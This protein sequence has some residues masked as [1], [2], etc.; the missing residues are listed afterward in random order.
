[1]QR[2]VLKIIVVILA[3]LHGVLAAQEKTLIWINVSENYGLE[4]ELEYV[5]FSVQLDAVL[6]E[7]DKISFF[8]Q[9]LNTAQT[10]DCQVSFI[11]S[12]SAHNKILARIIFPVSCRAYEKNEYLL[13]T[14][15]TEDIVYS[16]L[17]LRG[18]GTELIIENKYYRADLRKNDNVEPQSYMSGQ[19]RELLI[20]MGF[21]KLVTNVEDRLHW[22][23]NFKRPEL[24]YYTTIAH[25]QLPK[26]NEITEGPYQITTLRE[27][28]APDHP[29]ILLTAKYRFY[30]GLPYFRFYS[31]IEM[32]NDVWLELLRN[33][34]MAMDSM[35]THMAFERPNGEIVDVEFAERY[36][37]L[38]KHPIENDSPWLCFYNLD[39]GFA[40]GTIRIKYDNTDMY[41][42]ES[43][44]YQPHTQ[45]GEWLKGVKY[46]NRRLIHDHLTFVPKGSCYQ[47]D[48]AYLVFKINSN[49]KLKDIEYWSKQILHPLQVSIEYPNNNLK[50]D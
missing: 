25:W 42:N 16:D 50:G 27:D 5:E 26:I 41:G 45:I 10:I 28:L 17:I 30:S 23:P 4:R 36:D 33:D 39:K 9:E 32:K 8:V 49:D 37:L 22:A 18:K 35:F 48:N 38:K 15:K 31:R 19:I 29:E 13:K 46:W 43:P 34:E 2:K 20:K 7:N 21:N 12:G 1:M 14:K 44:T 47:E 40:F 24:E 11:Q 6:L 3:I